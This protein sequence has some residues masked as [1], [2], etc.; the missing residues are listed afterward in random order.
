MSQS[1]EHS[2]KKIGLT[3]DQAELV[4]QGLSLENT[5]LMSEYDF[6]TARNRFLGQCQAE[7]LDPAQSTDRV[8]VHQWMRRGLIEAV[9]QALINEKGPVQSVLEADPPFRP[10]SVAYQQAMHQ[11][12]IGEGLLELL[13]AQK[14][15]QASA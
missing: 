5:G 3:N 13:E 14:A 8:W 6:R 2:N 12:V 7:G 11:K 10:D 4:T 15:A 1:V 9:R